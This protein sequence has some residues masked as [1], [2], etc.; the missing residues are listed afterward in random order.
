MLIESNINPKESIYYIGFLLLKF[1]KSN[2]NTFGNIEEMYN[3]FMAYSDIKIDFSK[4]MLLIDW[5]FLN[6]VVE[7]NS[8][9]VIVFNVFK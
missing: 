2:K 8:N 7:T 6:N 3:E 5:L 4:F 1:I 9:G